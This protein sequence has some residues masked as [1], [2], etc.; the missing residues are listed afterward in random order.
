VRYLSIEVGLA[1][2]DL[3]G[4]RIPIARGATFDDVDDRNLRAIQ[5]DLAQQAVE[6][7]AGGP[8]EGD[9][10]LVLVESGAFTDE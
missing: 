5:P 4:L 6:Q 3:V 7:L 10:L 2:I 9:P 1:G 8:Y